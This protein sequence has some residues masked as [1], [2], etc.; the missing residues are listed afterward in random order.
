MSKK[1][2][3]DEISIE[4][5]NEV[6]SK[7][8]AFYE[9]NRDTI[10]ESDYKRV[11]S[12]DLWLRRHIRRRRGQVEQ[13]SQ[14]VIDVMQWRHK[15]KVS[16]MCDAKFPR[17][18]HEVSGIY[19]FKED[20]HGN[21]VLH[22]RIRLFQRIPAIIEKL[23]NYTI[24]QLV[25][26]DEM[27]AANGVGWVLLLDCTGTGIVNA[28]LEMANFLVSTLR[29]YFPSGQQYILIHNLPWYLTA[30]KNVVFAMLP[31]YV[32]NR[33]KS[34]S[35]TTLEDYITKNNLPDYLGG[36]TGDAYRVIPDGLKT[37][38][39]MSNDGEMPTINEQDLQKVAKYYEKVRSIIKENQSRT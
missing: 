14:F 31:G 26:I 37:T 39:Q 3:F 12:D 25:K 17:E 22:V 23:K 4:T 1:S 10:D 32:K 35:E 19:P 16:E 2:D 29:S 27:S 15:N 34:S 8:V 6:R 24:Y 13:S 7:F 21:L 11:M 30:L 20:V 28:D 18:F 38:M 33:I 36:E 5:L 9:S